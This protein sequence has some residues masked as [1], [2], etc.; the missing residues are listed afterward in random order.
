MSQQPGR[1]P[2]GPARPAA[3]T[4]ARPAPPGPRLNLR[5]AVD[6]SSLARPQQPVGSPRGAAPGGGAPARPGGVGGTGAAGGAGPAGPGAPAVV[7]DVTEETFGDVVVQQSLTVPVVVDLWATWCGPCKQLSPVLEK[8]AVE[9]GGRLL[10]AKVD[11]DANPQIAQAFQVQSIP[12]VVAVIKG[13]PVPL[14]QGAVPEAQVRQVLD[15]L[16]RVAAENGVD[17]TLGDAVGAEAGE[18]QDVEPPLPPLHQEAYDAIERDD[19]DAGADAF[20][21]AL[22]ENPAD[23]DAA[24]GL[25]Q[26]DLLRRTRGADPAAARAAAAQRP[27]DLEAQMLVAD[28]DLLGGHVEDAFARLVDLVRVTSGPERDQARQRLVELFEVVGGDD[29]R[30][31]RA[32]GALASALF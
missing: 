11:V 1:R 17:G 13:Q 19:L 2:P 31:A 16:L 8:L 20:R 26:V 12:T 30:V 14:F 7:V 22:A 9:Y 28:L 6:L 23:R 27:T 18:P 5:G 4:A 29:P 15:E 3:R 10:L 21:R 24:V 25:A 32:R